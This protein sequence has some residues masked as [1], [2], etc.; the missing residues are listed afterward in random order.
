M[1][2][3]YVTYYLSEIN[4]SNDLENLRNIR[5]ECRCF[6]TRCTKEIPIEDQKKWFESIDKNKIKPFLFQE[7]YDGILIC[8]PVG[9]GLLRIEDDCVLISGGL[10]SDYRGKGF[11]FVLFNL[12]I[13][14][15]KKY[16]LPIRLEVLKSNTVAVHL[17]NKLG[18]TKVKENDTICEMTYQGVDN[19]S[20]VQSK[21]VTESI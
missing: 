14:E 21:D 18:F 6:M 2:K 8:G 5:N 10:N 13:N 15:S 20:V 17:Y 3:S 16:N 12:L 9:Y 19:D 11:G 4:S 1:E 7:I